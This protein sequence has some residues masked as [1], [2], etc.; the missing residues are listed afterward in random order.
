MATLTIH[1]D[2]ILSNIKKVDSF[3]KQRGIQWSFITK[4]ACG[5][6]PV[7][8]KILHDEYLFNLHSIGDARLSNLKVIKD[9]NP[10]LK[11]I[12]IKPPAVNQVENVVEVADVS[13]NSSLKTIIELNEAAKKQ[14]KLHEVIVMIEMGELR[15]GIVRE[16]IISFY[17]KIFELSHI[18]I[19]GLG[20]NLGCMYGVEPT[21]DKLIQLSLYKLLLEEKFQKEIPLISGGSSITLPLVDKKLPQSVNH[22]RIGETVFHGFSLIDGKRFKNLSTKAFNFSA[23]II[24]LEKKDS[25]PDGL[26]SEANVGHA[27]AYANTTNMLTYKSILDFG[28]I[29]VDY[30]DL[31]P[32]DNSIQFVGTT[33]DMTVYDL[34]QNTEKHKVGSKIQFIPN[35]MATARLMNSKYIT[36]I[37]K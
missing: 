37:I 19:I 20:T 31:T 12:Y 9:I 8:E 21:Y 36:K 5:H 7:L 6:K 2:K 23:E 27:A 33:S 22:L 1:T 10:G 17:S 13:L 29:D 30:D 4:M 11:T 32:L 15:E 26:I 24:E 34:K 3:L 14:D 18:K 16:N 35:Y 28:T 25:I